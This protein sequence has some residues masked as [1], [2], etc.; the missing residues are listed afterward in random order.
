MSNCNNLYIG[1]YIKCQRVNKKVITYETYPSCFTTDCINSETKVNSEYC[2]KCGGIIE[3]FTNA[4]EK[5][6]KTYNDEKFS[7]WYWEQE[8]NETPN[9]L[10]YLHLATS[11]DKEFNYHYITPRNYY[12]DFGSYYWDMKYEQP[13]FLT[14]D[15]TD[16]LKAKAIEYVKQQ[17]KDILEMLLEYYPSY[18]IH[19][20]VVHDPEI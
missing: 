3:N 5:I 19:Y 8:Q 7:D 15:I 17:Y 6:E 4:V 12:S 1:T 20:G 2:P 14:L 9:E 11:E 16:E 13:D 10:K 18:T